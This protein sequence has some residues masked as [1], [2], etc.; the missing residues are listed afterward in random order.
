MRGNL[1]ATCLNF[2]QKLKDIVIHHK[3]PSFNFDYKSEIVNYITKHFDKEFKYLNLN[4]KKALLKAFISEDYTCIIGFPGSGKTTLISLLVSILAKMKK[5][6]LIVS[7]TNL[8]VDN[9]L[10]KLKEKRVDFV[11]VTS[12]VS[13]VLPEIRD[14]VLRSDRFHDFSKWKEYLGDL[15]VYGVTTLGISN[16]IIVNNV[17]DYCIVDEA[18]QI[19]EP[20]LLGPLLLCKKFVLVGDP[21][22]VKNILIKNYL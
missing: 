4:Q 9:I 19:F 21:F 3:K 1:I 11:R 18:C 7:H 17:Y 10:V 6:I 13:S 20:N 5:K 2:K 15:Y 12:N 22:Q 8:A 14:K 16:K